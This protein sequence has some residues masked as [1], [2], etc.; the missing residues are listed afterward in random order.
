MICVGDPELFLL[1]APTSYTQ[2]AQ[3]QNQY[4]VASALDTFIPATSG[5]ELVVSTAL[6]SLTA[7]EYPNAFNQISPA[8]YTSLATISFNS[9]VAQYNE[10]VQ[11]LGNIRVAG[12]G[13]STMGL[14]SSPIM[15]DSKN[16]KLTSTKSEKDI[17]IPSPDNHW[18]V[19]V[20]ANGI[21]DNVNIN[22]QLPAYNA[23][24][25]GVTFGGSYKW[26]EAFST[27][28]Y[29]GYEGMQSKQSGGNFIC[30]NGSRFGLFGTYQHGGLFGNAMVGGASHSYQIQRGISFSTLN[31]T[32]TSAPTAGELD[33]MLATGYDIKRG[34]FTFGPLTSLQY[35]YFGLQPFT[36]TG[37]Q[38]LD[39]SVA[40]ANA[41][42]LVYSLGSHAFYTWQVNKE[43]LILPQINLGWQHEFLQNPYALNSTLANGAS[44]NYMSTTPLRDSLYTGVGFTVNFAK[45]YDTSF[46]Y[47]ASA[48]NPSSMSQ[49]FFVSLGMNF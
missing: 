8:L 25:G 31:R 21:F 4:N 29:A 22:N 49:N 41:N 10:M 45:K 2:V 44:M 28:L 20:D 38:S 3:N 26:N 33:S 17:L 32:A 12:V 11:R 16:P 40:N 1:V 46:F 14:T 30:D 37:A 19:F 18:G 27:G 34:N 39:L 24:S 48:C 42:S 9:A 36:E 35:T 7:A 47:N 43:T 6:D 15:D 23:E 13:F 5:D